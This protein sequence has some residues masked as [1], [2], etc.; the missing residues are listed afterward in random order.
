MSLYLQEYHNFYHNKKHQYKFRLLNNMHLAYTILKH[1]LA[2]YC[3]K[4]LNTTPYFM[5]IFHLMT[6]HLLHITLSNY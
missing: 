4:Q 6:R 1:V 2:T 5:L 3:T